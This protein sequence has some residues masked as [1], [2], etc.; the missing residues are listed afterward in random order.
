MHSVLHGRIGSGSNDLASLL[1]ME[2]HA[3]GNGIQHVVFSMRFI[4][5]DPAVPSPEVLD[6]LPEGGWGPERSS[7]G[8]GLTSIHDQPNAGNIHGSIKSSSEANGLEDVAVW[9]TNGDAVLW[10]LRPAVL[11]RRQ[12]NARFQAECRVKIKVAKSKETKYVGVES[13]RIGSSNIVFDPAVAVSNKWSVAAENLQEF[14]K[15]LKT[16]GQKSAAALMSMSEQGRHCLMSLSAPQQQNLYLSNLQRTLVPGAA[17]EAQSDI[18]EW[19][20]NRGHP[21]VLWIHGPPGSGKTTLAASLVQKL[22]NIMNDDETGTKLLAYYFH[23]PQ[24]RSIQRASVVLRS[25]IHQIVLQKPEV[26]KHVLNVYQ[27]PS[28][29][30]KLFNDHTLLWHSLRQIIQDP[31]VQTM[32]FIIDGLDECDEALLDIA[33]SLNRD[34]NTLSQAKSQQISSYRGKWILISRDQPAIEDALSGCFALDIRSKTESDIE[35]F[36]AASVDRLDVNEDMKTSLKR[37][38]AQKA[39]RSFLWA[40]LALDALKNTRATPL[41]I[42]KELNSAPMTLSTVYDQSLSRSLAIPDAETRKL[43]QSVLLLAGISFAPLSLSTL[44]ILAEDI[45]GLQTTEENLKSMIGDA[46]H[47]LVELNGDD[48]VLV[49]HSLREYLSSPATIAKLHREKLPDIHKSVSTRCLSYICDSLAEESAAHNPAPRMGDSDLLKYPILYWMKHGSISSQTVEDLQSLFTSNLFFEKESKIR[50]AWLTKYWMFKYGVSET[51]PANFTMMH[52][53]AEAGYT[54]LTRVLCDTQYKTDINTRDGSERTPLHWAAA[55]GYCEVARLLLENGADANARSADQSSVLQIAIQAGG[56]DMVQLLLDKGVYFEREMLREARAELKQLLQSHVHLT[57]KPLLENRRVDGRFWGRMVEI[58]SSQRCHSKAVRVD[59]ILNPDVSFD[60]LMVDGRPQ[61]FLN[62]GDKLVRWVHLPENNMEWVEVLITKILGTPEATANVLRSDLWS[63]RVRSTEKHFYSRCLRPVCTDFPYDSLN[64]SNHRGS[65]AMLAIPYLHWAMN[66]ERL[67][68]KNTVHLIKNGNNSLPNTE[69]L[70]HTSGNKHRELLQTYLGRDHPLHV[71]RT[72]DQFYYFNLND[73]DMDLRDKDQTIS[74]YFRNNMMNNSLR[75]STKTPQNLDFPILM[76]DQLWLWVLEDNT[77]ITS[78]PYRWVND[79]S[80]DS[81]N[82][83]DVVA[84]VE[85]K[86]LSKAWPVSIDSGTKLAELIANECSGIMFDLAKHRDKWIHTQEIYEDAIGNLANRESSLFRTFSQALKMSR[87]WGAEGGEKER[88][89]IKEEVELLDD[90][91]DI[92]DELNM[93]R[94]I[95]ETQKSAVEGTGMFCNFSRLVDSR[96]KDMD[97]IDQRA[98]RTQDALSHLLDLKQK[99]ANAEET[100][101]LSVQN[102]ES[103]KQSQAIMTFTVVTIIFAPLSF[104]TSFFAIEIADF[105]TLT[106]GFVLK[107]LFPVTFAVVLV[108]CTL[109][110]WDILKERFIK[111]RGPKNKNQASSKKEKAV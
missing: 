35:A 41:Q 100:H 39:D 93:I 54:Q 68:L 61:T 103:G 44:P 40:R 77:V 71:R 88:Y 106:V 105:P 19:L 78:F 107:Y 25:L 74:K 85:R 7:K 94:T 76:V 55:N 30:D 96:L 47:P 49:H 21:R 2:V 26:V 23:I 53:A 17:Q 52:M 1:M 73:K 5:V 72:L 57:Y 45:Y 20:Y 102:I 59:L 70:I 13:L 99:Q 14:M 56:R 98:A 81:Y 58:G 83:T 42:S 32:F 101:F 29:G 33:R 4:S 37:T 84:A 18:M 60:N 36:I 3:P 79:G 67:M 89:A 8:A 92:R 95:F 50:S 43:A 69:P 22:Q 104:L 75:G 62:D 46:C 6:I 12:S 65:R 66:E 97:R 15:D 109:A 91:K 108:C 63:D 82:M 90:I 10:L 31:E 87:D 111:L 51:Q 86:I 11:I 64:V 24:E 28:V 38:I 27:E 16:T 34:S 48:V 80:I 9:K 110:F